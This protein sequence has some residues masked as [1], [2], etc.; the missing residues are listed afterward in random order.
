MTTDAAVDRYPPSPFDTPVTRAAIASLARVVTVSAQIA[1][2]QA[3]PIES[4]LSSMLVRL[5]RGDRTGMLRVGTFP[6]RDLRPALQAEHAHHGWSP[7]NQLA[8]I[9]PRPHADVSHASVADALEAACA[10][11]D[12]AD[13]LTGAAL[14]R[15]RRGE[16]RLRV[17]R[18]ASSRRAAEEYAIAHHH[19]ALAPEDSPWL[20][21]LSH[22]QLTARRHGLT[23]AGT[24]RAGKLA[25]RLYAVRFPPNESH[26]VRDFTASPLVRA[27]PPIGFDVLHA[28]FAD[29]AQP[30][31]EALQRS[32]W[33]ALQGWPPAWRLEQHRIL[34]EWALSDPYA[35]LLRDDAH[36]TI[37]APL[38][39]I[40][41]HGR[42]ET[43][44]FRDGSLTDRDE[45]AATALWLDH[46]DPSGASSWAVVT[47]AQ[48]YRYFRSPL[49][50][51]GGHPPFDSAVVP[52]ASTRDIRAGVEHFTVGGRVVTI[53]P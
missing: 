10:R 11:L 27:R 22:A 43:W 41:T 12:S 49:P 7:A 50:R 19:A 48:R 31:V 28:L 35:D 53:T 32:L 6:V 14:A 8:D 24:M 13:H 42:P 15:A 45:F 46:R 33:T 38:D 18:Q 52:Y 9:A 40:E 37:T 34:R 16:T 47:E 39:Y 29:G 17:I 23:W 20:T 4:G 1:D 44:T 5:T 2:L 26:D 21:V 25:E 3:E 51:W 30:E 36:R